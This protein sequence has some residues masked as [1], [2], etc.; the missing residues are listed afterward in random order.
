MST[1]DYLKPGFEKPPTDY[2]Q[3]PLLLAI[4]EKLE[5]KELTGLKYCIGPR[6]Y[7]E[8]VYDFGVE[9]AERFLGKPIFGLFWTNTFSHNDWIDP[10]TMDTR[11][12]EYF[13]YMNKTGIL[14]NNI[15]VLFSDHGARWG[16]LRSQ[17]EGYIEERLPMFFM[18]LPQW[19]QTQHPDIVESLIV[20]K[21][22][23]TSPYD[24]HVTLKHLA[25]IS[26]GK[27]G[28]IQLPSSCPTCQ[29]LLQPVPQNRT[30]PMAGIED[31]W[32]TC[33][34]FESL[35]TD[36]IEMKNLTNLVIYKMNEYL[37]SGPYADRCVSTMSLHRI[38]EAN[39]KLDLHTDTHKSRIQEYRINFIID[40]NEAEFE[41]TFL[42]DRKTRTVLV[43]VTEI[44]RLNRYADDS[45][46]IDDNIV[47]K[48]CI[49]NDS[50][51]EKKN[52]K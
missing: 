29:T 24:I 20:N 26:L 39:L 40:P 16:F 2:Y 19:F 44:S 45:K 52:N 22:R 27:N 11:M 41:A 10:A 37:Q 47:K 36:S 14:D 18:R 49:C 50:V 51:K 12:V 28:T 35:D 34:P 23:L 31:H 15:V 46:C 13:E 30:C 42:Y 32:C 25:L 17:K 4:E 43:D 33:T 3:R 8:Y 6:R 21:N 7:G 38:I 48:Y 5:A 9:F 1:F